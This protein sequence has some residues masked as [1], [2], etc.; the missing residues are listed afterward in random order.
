MT[1]IPQIQDALLDE[2]VYL[3]PD[4]ANL[5]ISINNIHQKPVDSKNNPPL[6]IIANSNTEGILSPETV[7]MLSK[8]LVALRLPAENIPVIPFQ[9]TQILPLFPLLNLL[10]PGCVLVLGPTGKT[11]HF[12]PEYTMYKQLIF[13]NI[14]FLFCDAPE[15]LDNQRKKVL[16]KRLQEV[17]NL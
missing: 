9:T 6:L 1:E 4:S 17:F 5:T 16:W 11:L 14:S 12:Y 7:D 13:R 10:N 3:I 8:M 2:M 15:D